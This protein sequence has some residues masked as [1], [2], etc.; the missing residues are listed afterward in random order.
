MFPLPAPYRRG[1]HLDP[2]GPQGQ[3]L[4]HH[5]VH[6]LPFDGLAALWAMG[7]ADAGIEQAE[8]IVDLRH[9][10]HGGAGVVGGAFL[11]DADGRGKP[12]DIVHVG[13]FHL[14]QKLP[15]I[16]GQGFHI[17]P[18]AFGV[19]GIKGQ[20]GFAAAGKAG[21]YDQLIPGQGQVYVL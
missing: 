12:L 15:G 9:R 1:D 10:A 2:A 16:G 7:L 14:A 6:R 8:I 5:L 4:I 11:V 19:N 18:L 13:L 3:D 20:G 21:E 17:P